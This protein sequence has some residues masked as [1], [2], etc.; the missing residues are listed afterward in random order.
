[1]ETLQEQEAEFSTFNILM[2]DTVRQGMCVVD[3]MG[4]N[5]YAG[6]KKFSNWPTYPQ[7][8]INGELIGG[9]DSVL[10]CSAH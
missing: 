4:F 8:Y 1:M 2:D 6:L 9:L 7:L 5:M 10:V 3:L